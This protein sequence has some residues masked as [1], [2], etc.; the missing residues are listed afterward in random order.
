M[1]ELERETGGPAGAIPAEEFRQVLGKKLDLES[2]ERRSG[3]A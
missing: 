2:F 3:D 1:V